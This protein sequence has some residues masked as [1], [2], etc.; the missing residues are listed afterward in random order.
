MRHVLTLLLFVLVVPFMPAAAFAATAP[1]DLAA[2]L[3]DWRARSLP[4]SVETLVASMLPPAREAGDRM[5]VAMLALE[6]GMTRVAYGRA[7]DGEADLREALALAEASG[8]TP[9]ALK[10]LRYLAEAC[11][12]LGRRDESAATFAELESRARAAGDGFHTGKALYGRGRLLYRARDLAGADSLY[13]AA[14]PFL[15]AAADSADLAALFNGL[16]NC[17]AGRGAYRDAAAHY[18]RAAVMA[19]GGGS[20]SLE[21]MAANNLAGI[22]MILGDPGAAVAGYRRARDIQRELELWQQAGAPWRNLASALLELGSP[23]EAGAE[24]EAALVFCR[25]R[26][27]RDE[28]AL[29]LVRLAEVDLAAGRYAAA[30]ARCREAL[31]SDAE[32][33][34][35][36]LSNAR[37]AA[38]DALL[39]LDRGDEALAECAAAAASLEGRDDFILEMQLAAGRSRV[40]RALGRHAEALAVVAPA[41]A[42]A[43][44]ADVARHRLPLLV[45]GAESWRALAAADSAGVWLDAAQRLWERERALPADPQW[46]ERRGAE[47]QRL[48]ELRLGLAMERPDP[49][50]AFDAA[51]RYKARTMLERILGPGEELPV[52]GEAPPITLHDLQA[53]VLKPG[54]VLLDV[55][56]GRDRGWLFVVTRDDLLA[57]P[58]PGGDGWE[59]VLAPLF[60]QLAHPFDDFDARGAA[61]ARDTLLGAPG[62][63]A[64]ATVAGAATV[65]VCPDG[66]LHRAPFA[67]LLAPAEPRRLPSATVLA[68]LRARAAPPPPAACV[69]AVAGHEN[70]ARGR[71]SG[72]EAEVARLRRRFRRVTVPSAARTDTAAFGGAVVESFDVLHFASHG[73]VDAQRPWNSAL[74]FGDAERP[75]RVRAGD[76]ARLDLKAQLAVLSSCGSADG[77]L[78]AGEGVPGLASGFLS[79]GVP[80]V[81]ATLWP[82]DDAATSRLIGVFYDELAAGRPPAAALGAARTALRDDPATSHP[83]YWAGFVLLG[84][85][86]TPVRLQPRRV[87]RSLVAGIAVITV[88]GVVAAPVLRRRRSS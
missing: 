47:A 18:A 87:P 70:S 50:A 79:A 1:A 39:G 67:L 42:A 65:F 68:H 78:V 61:A 41:L 56:A 60:A 77:Q 30:Y 9:A 71:L 28:E 72:A 31:A 6:R 33:A 10:A 15:E 59:A 36:V 38:A 25:E 88:A 13:S 7:A 81:V 16:G 21:A 46:R 32:L 85:G 49:V 3:A 12:H 29:T 51:Q 82:V 5:L 43:T 26:G 20:R 45:A 75:L 24:L 11:Q 86:D 74:V 76:I 8:D 35:D 48:F 84:E 62:S 54:E 37:L 27:F 34:P 44:A 53:A 19:R 23:D 55:F 58:L 17:R 40:L 4:D 73:E 66:V 83:F 57:R 69:L 80:A 64:A 63:P 14:R 52:A 2:R 22:E